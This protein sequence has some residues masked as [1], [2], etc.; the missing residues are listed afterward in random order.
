MR[1]AGALDLVAVTPAADSKPVICQLSNPAQQDAFL[2]GASFSRGAL[3]RPQDVN[4]IE[5]SGTA[6]IDEDGKSLY[7]GDIRSQIA[8]TLDKIEVLIGQVGAR[9]GDICAASV[10]V[11]RSEYASIFWEMAARR[12]IE[13]F[14]GICVVADMCRDELLFEIDAEVAFAERS[15]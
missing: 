11:K 5:V 12:G 13:E 15:M 9:L 10:F 4:L 2:Y 14:P 8:C 1:A 6:A 7:P 3:I